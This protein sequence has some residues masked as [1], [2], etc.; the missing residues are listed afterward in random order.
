M[1]VNEKARASPGSSETSSSLNEDSI[2]IDLVTTDPVRREKYLVEL[3]QGS[4]ITKEDIMKLGLS[5]G[6]GWTKTHE[7]ITLY[8]DTTLA[9]Q[10]TCSKWIEVYGDRL[11]KVTAIKKLR[12]ALWSINHGRIAGQLTQSCSCTAIAFK[13]E[14]IYT[15][16]LG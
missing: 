13:V 16:R 3:F 9:G 15:C 11:N 8:T 7:I 12:R 10:R 2:V 1:I 14:G 4:S 6:V 5:L